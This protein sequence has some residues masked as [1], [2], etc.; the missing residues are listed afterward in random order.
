MHDGRVDIHCAPGLSD[1]PI[2]E[3]LD[4]LAFSSETLS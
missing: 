1:E 2:P 3:V 4:E